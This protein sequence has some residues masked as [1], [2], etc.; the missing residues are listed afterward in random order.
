MATTVLKGSTKGAIVSGLNA[1]GGAAEISGVFLSNYNTSI[2]SAQVDPVNP[3]RIIIGGTNPGT[4]Q[5]TVNAKN[6]LNQFIST[7]ETVTVE[8]PPPATQLVVTWEN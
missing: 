8:L 4:T 2:I 5:I 3:L 7:V 6:N 1:Q